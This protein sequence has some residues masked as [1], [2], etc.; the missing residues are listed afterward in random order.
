MINM[1]DDRLEFCTYLTVY[2]GERLP[3]R[4]IGSSNVDKVRSGYNGSIQSRRWKL[5]YKEEQKAHK[6]LF[7]TRILQRF[8]TRVEAFESELN[9]QIKYNVVK[10]GSYMNLSLARKKG[11]FGGAGEDNYMFGRTHT[12]EAIEKIIQARTGSQA[13]DETK[14]KMSKIHSRENLSIKRLQQ[15]SDSYTGDKNP[16]YGKYGADHPKFGRKMSDENLRLLS[17]RFKGKPKTKE[18]I[19]RRCEKRRKTFVV[20]HSTGDVVIVTNAKEYCASRGYNYSSFMS[21]S[22]R[23][24]IWRPN[25]G[26]VSL[27]IVAQPSKIEGGSNGT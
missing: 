15:M 3:R 5:I 1:A 10:D 13:S 25:G 8:S 4:Y 17:V 27:T 16:M 24:A 20:T 9:L 6:H 12:P 19:M 18:S 26:D 11:Y 21:A 22:N 2:T 14:Q 23:G 7:K